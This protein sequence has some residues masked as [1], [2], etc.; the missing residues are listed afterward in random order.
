MI[1]ESRRRDAWKQLL[2]RVEDQQSDSSYR[3]QLLLKLVSDLRATLIG[4]A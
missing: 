3:Y 4:G 1:F 2:K